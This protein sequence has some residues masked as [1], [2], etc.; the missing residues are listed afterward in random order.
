MLRPNTNVH[1]W[2]SIYRERPE[3]FAKILKDVGITED[4]KDLIL[5]SFPNKV[6][7]FRAYHIEDYKGVEKNIK[8]FKNDILSEAFDVGRLAKKLMTED[9][10]KNRNFK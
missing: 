2:T 6:I 9:G 5:D 1:E 10:V 7:N 4:N 8:R 3:V